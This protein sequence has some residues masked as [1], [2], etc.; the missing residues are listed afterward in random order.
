MGSGVVVQEE[1]DFLDYI[2]LV[3]E[4]HT[5]NHWLLDPKDLYT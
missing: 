2:M 5:T 1:G 4:G 3:P